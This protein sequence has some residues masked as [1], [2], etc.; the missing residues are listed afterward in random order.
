MSLCNQCN[1]E[2]GFGLEFSLGSAVYIS[3][4]FFG[5][6]VNVFVCENPECPNYGLLQIPQEIM[7]KEDK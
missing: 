6:E 5:G 7:R 3:P 1:R 2:M 4:G